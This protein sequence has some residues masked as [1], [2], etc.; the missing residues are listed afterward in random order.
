MSEIKQYIVENHQ[1]VCNSD[2][3][4]PVVFN[5]EPRRSSLYIDGGVTPLPE[6]MG[7]K[8]TA[9][10][11]KFGATLRSLGEAIPRRASLGTGA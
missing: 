4:C 11:A 1:M 8:L 2:Y 3:G 10:F 9:Q 6:P 7:Q 5:G